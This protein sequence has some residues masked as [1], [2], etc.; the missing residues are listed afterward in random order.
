[1]AIRP[2]LAEMAGEMQAWRRALHAHPETAYEEHR[3]ADFVAEKLTGWGIE[4]HRG[5]AGT[6]VVGVLRAGQSPRSIGLRADMDALD[7][8]E[9]NRFEHRSRTPGKM[10]ACGHDGHMAML[11]GSAQRLAA[12]RRFDG[13]IYFIFQ[14]AEE[15]EAGARRMVQEGLFEQFPMDAVFGMHNFPVIAEGKIVVRPGPMMA[16]ADFFEVT[17]TGRGAHGAW[18][19]QGVDAIGVACEMVRAFN[20]IVARTVDPMEAAVISVT[21]F[22]AGQNT[23]V[24]P[25]T[26]AFAGTT[27]T[28]SLEV[29]ASLEAQMRRVCEGVA[30]AHGASVAFRYD[31]RYPPTLNHPE[32]TRFAAAV[33][34]R[35]VGPENVLR[36]VPPVMGAEDFAWMLLEKRGSY[37]W[38]G[39]GP[40]HQ[41]GCMLHNPGYDFNDR[42]LPV[43]ASYW[44]ELAEAWLA[45]G[46][47]DP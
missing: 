27:R 39:N 19:H 23:N 44:V 6:G 2:E 28:F 29:Q 31:R 15:N 45:P 24:L 14:P 1:M 17:V 13:T 10:H 7:L 41:G 18:P 8:E 38:I 20:H 12:T 47:A 32:E 21:R 16:S 40:E 46:R 34:E 43:G 42:I 26:A 35:V 36:D 4:V 11:L 30:A 22:H 9:G 37:V 25:E 5:L 33:A 3:T